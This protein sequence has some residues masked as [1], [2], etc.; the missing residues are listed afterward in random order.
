MPLL[1]ATPKRRV[2]CGRL[3]N[4]AL[5]RNVPSTQPRRSALNMLRHSSMQGRNASPLRRIRQPRS[6]AAAAVAA[7][8][9]AAVD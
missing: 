8:V 1:R 4:V 2:L 5:R 3:L 7:V 6:M 9:V